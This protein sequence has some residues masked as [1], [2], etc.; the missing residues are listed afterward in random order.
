LLASQ[1]EPTT[2]N[3]GAFEQIALS[4]LLTKVS[5][6][7]QNK[8]LMPSII[9]KLSFGGVS[10]TVMSTIYKESRLCMTLN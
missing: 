8:T 2:F 10:V 6:F 9:T 1:A 4:F 3:D 7:K 5:Y